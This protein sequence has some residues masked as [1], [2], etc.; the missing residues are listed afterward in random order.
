MSGE[1]QRYPHRTTA[2]SLPQA[3]PSAPTARRLRGPGHLGLRRAAGLRGKRP[4]PPQPTALAA[5][6]SPARQEADPL[7]GAVAWRRRGERERGTLPHAGRRSTCMLLLQNVPAALLR[8]RGRMAV[9]AAADPAAAGLGC[10]PA[11]ACGRGHRVPHGKGLY[12]P[13]ACDA[14][15]SARRSALLAR[16]C[17]GTLA[18]GALLL[19]LT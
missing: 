18:R 19:S 14:R 10:D 4:P 16:G 7:Q 17:R 8:R 6:T 1:N 5:G 15:S 9:A 3:P 2:A 12:P 13:C 11:A